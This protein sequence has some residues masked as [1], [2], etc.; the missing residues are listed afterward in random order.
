MRVQP[1]QAI[2]AYA[3]VLRN[4]YRLTVDQDLQGRV[5][6]IF[7]ALAALTI[8]AVYRGL[9]LDGAPFENDE[10]GEK[11]HDDDCDDGDSP[12]PIPSTGTQRHPPA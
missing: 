1:E 7:E 8:D 10:G 4:G 5:Y 9:R 6:V 12:Q 11:N 2:A 3:S